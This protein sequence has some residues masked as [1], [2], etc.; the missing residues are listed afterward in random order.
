MEIKKYLKNKVGASMM[1][2]FIISAVSILIGGAIFIMGSQ[3]REGVQTGTN[4]IQTINET[5]RN[6]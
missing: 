3:V 2:Y 6:G 1:D 5:L 4:R